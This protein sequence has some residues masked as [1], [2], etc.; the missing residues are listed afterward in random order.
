MFLTVSESGSFAV[1]TFAEGIEENSNDVTTDDEGDK[2]NHR[3][4][5][6]QG[7]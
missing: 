5:F 2:H 3:S 7:Y 4:G 1:Q 6:L